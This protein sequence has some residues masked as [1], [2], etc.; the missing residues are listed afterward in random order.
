MGVS[1]TQTQ[2]GEYNVSRSFLS[3]NLV[4]EAG[5]LFL[6]LGEGGEVKEKISGSDIGLTLAFTLALRLHLHF[7]TCF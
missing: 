6:H 7:V 5:A 1:R 3:L 2:K 4:L